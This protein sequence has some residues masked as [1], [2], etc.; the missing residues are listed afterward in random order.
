MTV[1][2]S[3]VDHAGL[4]L[5]LPVEQLMTHINEG[6][7]DIVSC[8]AGDGC[9]C[10]H[11]AAPDIEEVQTMA[12]HRLPA[13]NYV[14]ARLL[15][16]GSMLFAFPPSKLQM[17]AVFAANGSSAAV[18]YNMSNKTSA[19][20]SGHLE[21]TPTFSKSGTNIV[22]VTVSIHARAVT[23]ALSAGLALGLGLKRLEVFTQGYGCDGSDSHSVHTEND[24]K[25][26]NPMVPLMLSN[27]KDPHRQDHVTNRKLGHI[28]NSNQTTLWAAPLDTAVSNVAIKRYEVPKRVPMQPMVY[29]GRPTRMCDVW[30]WSV[31]NVR[32]AI[33]SLHDLPTIGLSDVSWYTKRRNRGRGTIGSPPIVGHQGIFFEQSSMRT[34]LATARAEGKSMITFGRGTVGG[35]SGKYLAVL[36][37]GVAEKYCYTFH[38]V[39]EAADDSTFSEDLR[40]VEI[41][42]DDCVWIQHAV[43]W[44]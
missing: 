8:Q 33:C 5:F 20:L 16:D 18:R 30:V 9:T 22:A 24:R 26:S 31:C 1:R 39:V 35:V 17:A 29:A 11:I 36:Y 10:L 15:E 3:I 7:E 38:P 13:A 41:A 2:A 32:D 19:G 40:R 12:L 23:Q 25:G 37:E 6:S 34:R 28:T 4:G 44:H 21:L 27:P 42:E 43:W 14:L